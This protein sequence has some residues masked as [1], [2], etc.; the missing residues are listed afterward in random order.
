MAT[1]PKRVVSGDCSKQQQGRPID[2]V[3]PSAAV[4]V[5]RP[6]AKAEDQGSDFD[7]RHNDPVRLY[8][9]QMGGLG[10]LTRE[11]E[12]AIARRFADG[13]RRVLQALLASR[14][15]LHEM[16]EVS[17]ALKRGEMR[18]REVVSELE[19]DPE[20]DENWHTERLVKVIERARTLDAA[21]ETLRTKL[22]QRGLAKAMRLKHRQA[23]AKN[24]AEIC[25]LFGE[26][27]LDS[28]LIGRMAQRVKS[29]GDEARHHSA[30][31][32]EV[33]T[34]TGL[35]TREL[36]KAAREAGRS[37]SAEQRIQRDLGLGAHELAELA[38]QVRQAQRETQRINA[39][40][41]QSTAE[42]LQTQ[43]EVAEGQRMADKAKAEMVEANLRLVVSIAKKYINR[44]MP[45]LDLIQEGNIGLMRA[46]DKFDYKRGYKFSTYATWWIRQAMTR[47]IADQARTIRV[48]VH[49]VEMINK[50]RRVTQ[51]LVQE[52][53]REPTPEE[54]AQRLEVPVDRVHTVLEASKYAISLETPVGEDDGA[55]LVDLIEDDQVEDPSDAVDNRNLSAETG[56]VLA[57]LTPRE[58]K[59]LRMRF[60]IG[61]ASDHT[62]E[63]VGQDF[64]VTRERIRQIQAKALRK[65]SSPS[66][67]KPL[68]VFW[69]H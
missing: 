15:A 19:E 38:R 48:P 3:M 39:L 32:E 40:T 20:L 56:R 58:E 52:L 12:V 27:Q 16:L 65:L 45:F 69:D 31:I 11:G 8:L 14:V 59:I 25:A 35:N 55:R 24:S 43:R 6:V 18:P 2:F 4:R 37:A 33:R 47:A 51:P 49:M 66:R 61:E 30:R 21:N 9:R 5:T 41:A 62:L 7:D 29:L 60:G 50:V 64:N 53:G 42:L 67:S 26:L 63:E 13:Q 17:E 28:R 36:N 22:K 10:L 46:V 23:L 68:K 57:T 34:R 54:V 1:S 44:G